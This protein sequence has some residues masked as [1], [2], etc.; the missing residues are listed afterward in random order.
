MKMIV[1]AIAVLLATAQWAEP[2]AAWSSANRYGGSTSHSAG[3]TSH[4]NAYG[5]SSSHTWGQG[6]SHTNAYGGSTSHSYGGGTSHTNVYGGTTSGAYGAGWS[7]SYPS[8]ATAYRP[9]GYATYPVYHPP[10]AVPYYSSG[11]YGCAAAVGAIAGAAVGAAAASANT[12]AATSNAYAAGVATGSA[13][14]AAATGAAYSAGVA[15]GVSASGGTYVMGVKYAS[16]PT[17]CASP[18]VGGTSYVLCGNTW[19]RPSYGANG[20]FYTVVPTP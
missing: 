10:V 17:G 20:V 4:T 18:N 13:N 19:F 14:A 8:G 7:H 16:V 2:A 1:T 11:C 3:S 6:S 15:A 12:A 9:P 5:G